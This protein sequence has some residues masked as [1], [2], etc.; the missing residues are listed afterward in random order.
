MTWTMIEPFKFKTSHNPL[1]TEHI[2]AAGVNAG[3]TQNDFSS[4]FTVS[5]K[6]PFF[7]KKNQSFARSFGVRFIN[8][9]L[10]SVSLFLILTFR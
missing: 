3:L 6:F 4:N 9:V 8:S 10:S 1:H 2:Q 7:F 5:D